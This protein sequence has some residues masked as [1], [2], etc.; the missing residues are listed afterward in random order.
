M[1][2]HRLLCAAALLLLLTAGVPAMAQDEPPAANPGDTA[3]MLMSSALVMLM[4]PGLALFYAGMVRGKNVLSSLMHSMVALGVMTLQWVIIGY[5]LAF[6]PDI[7]GVIGGLDHLFLRGMNYETLTGD[8]PH[9]Y[10]LYVFV[11]FQ[12]MFAIITPALISGAIAERIRFSAY[13]LFILIWGTV[14]YAPLCHW[15]WGGGWL[16][17]RGALDF[18]GGTVVHI[19][20]GSSALVLCYLLGK[21]RG[22]P[23]GEMLP[24]NLGMTVLGAGLLWFGWFGFNAGSALASDA[25]AGLAFTVT[26]IASAAGMCGWLIAERVHTGKA[27]VL[28]GASGIVAGLV[29]IT[30]A[31]GFVE[32]MWAIVIGVGAGVFCYLGVQL[33]HSF[34]YDDSLDVF[35]VHCIG[36]IWGALAT[37]LFS[38]V[39]AD[40]SPVGLLTSGQPGQFIEQIIGVVATLAFAMIGTLIIAKVID[41]TIGLR[42]SDESEEFGL[43][44]TEHGETG[45]NI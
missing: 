21:R 34:G 10:P 43:D 8:A 5:T 1:K 7:G 25:N 19:S 36:G 28:G 16:G 42:V 23:S 33:K 4:L 12:G 44:Q 35:G 13:V 24:H 2:N 26:H 40:D 20:S 14:I 15:V 37:G 18:A 9:Q 31:A 29:A 27:S 6:G 32:P 30:P 22:Y 41:A 3:W 45:Y 11:M 38:T 39:G 17:E